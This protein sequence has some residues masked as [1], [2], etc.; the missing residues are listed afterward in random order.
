MMND[1]LAGVSFVLQKV[2]T[3]YRVQF[4]FK[5]ETKNRFPLERIFFVDILIS[6]HE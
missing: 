6:I 4:E 1:L 3:V 5:K 2:K